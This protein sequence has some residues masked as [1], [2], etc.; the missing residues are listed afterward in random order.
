MSH[1]VTIN[2]SADLTTRVYIDGVELRYIVGYT[3]KQH[4]SVQSPIAIEVVHHT[5]DPHP[6]ESTK[7]Y[8]IRELTIT[9]YEQLTGGAVPRGNAV[10]KTIEE[11]Q[12][13]CHRRARNAGWWDEYDTMP[14]SCRKHFIAGKIALV[15]SE[16]SEALEG[17]RKG[18]ADAHIPHRPATEVEFADSII[19]IM[20][21]AGA[22]ELDVAGAIID[23]MGYNSHRPDHTREARAAEGGKS[24]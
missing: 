15:H 23:K 7:V 11:L 12:E 5:Y 3:I 19:R 24:L 16:V 2:Q 6:V 20:D 10:S 21:L 1:K 18:L 8:P 9:G 4:N 14:E 22:L 17:F 13:E